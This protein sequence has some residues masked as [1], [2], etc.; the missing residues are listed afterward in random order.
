MAY[1]SA[2]SDQS[3]RKD[4]GIAEAQNSQ[5]HIASP[6]VLVDDE[7][8]CLLVY[9]RGL[10]GRTAQ[11]TRVAEST[12]GLSFSAL[13]AIIW[14][15]FFRGEWFGLAM[16]GILYQSDTGAEHFL[17][18]RKLLFDPDMRHA[19]LWLKDNRL[20]VFGPK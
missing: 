20:Y 8:Q 18:C 17:P 9:Y 12:D 7:N 13:P 2:V 5:S 3:I 6:N 11:Y 16:P 19:G 14:K 4:R 15:H 1:R 10:A